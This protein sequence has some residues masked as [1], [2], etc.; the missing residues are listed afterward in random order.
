MVDNEHTGRKQRRTAEKKEK[1][2]KAAAQLFSQKG[3]S[4][5]TIKELAEIADISEGTIYNYFDDKEHLLF[6]LLEKLIEEQNEFGMYTK[7]LPSDTR[8]FLYAIFDMQHQFLSDN[9]E[10]FQAVFSEVLINHDYREMFF[11]DF[12]DPAISFFILQFQA[13]GVLGQIRPVNHL[14]LSHSLVAI[15]FGFYMLQLLEDDVIDNN[16]ENLLGETISLLYEGLST[17]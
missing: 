15:Q 14:P 11:D 8:S 13:R 7:T 2:L 1:I 6:S 5:S 9:R 3:F 10:L 17:V 16:W 4:A 12:V